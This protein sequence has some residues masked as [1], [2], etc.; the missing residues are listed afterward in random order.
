MAWSCFFLVAVMGGVLAGS[1]ARLTALAVL[2]SL[3]AIC[4]LLLTVARYET[5]VALGFAVFGVLLVEPALPDL[6]FGIVM[7]V[8]LLTGRTRSTLR[9][10]PPLVVYALGLFIVL[11]LFALAAAESVGH[12]VFFLAI[13]TYLALFGVWVAGYV[14]SKARAR[15]LVASLVIGATITGVLAI[16]ALFAPFPGSAQLVYFS[17]AKGFFDDPN[18]FGP[19]MVVPFALILAELVEPTLLAWRRRWL[20]AILLVSGAG[21]LFSYSRAAWLNTGL[22]VVAMIVAYALRRG[23]L[24]QAT[25]TVG[26]GIAAVGA[27][28]ALLFL[29]GSTNFLLARAHL[30]AYDTDRFQGQDESINLARTHIFGIGPGQYLDVVGIGAHSTFMRALGEE[31]VLGLALVAL[32]LL[33]TLIFAAGNVVHGRS[34]FGISAVPLLALWIGLIANSI[35]VDT[36]HWR[37]LWLVAGLIWAGATRVG[38][39]GAHSTPRPGHALRGMTG[40][41]PRIEPHARPGRVSR[42]VGRPPLGESS[43]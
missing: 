31:G 32:L 22:V 15:R 38:A 8:S 21:V 12:G 33:A 28:I 11:N 37:H 36:L 26:L 34:T 40:A 3:A 10:S 25:K 35:F 29:T 42:S 27:V 16:I 41:A 30:Q 9:H 6:I 2:G 43:Y 14:D 13:T 1:S 7:L 5:V 39:Q 4:L 17:R 18:V 24:R 19:F 20:V 23:G